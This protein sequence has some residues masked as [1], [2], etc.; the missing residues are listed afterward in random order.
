MQGAYDPAVYRALKWRRRR[1]QRRVILEPW[2]CRTGEKPGGHIGLQMR[3]WL[4]R[5]VRRPHAVSVVATKILVALVSTSTPE[6]AK[7]A[8][9]TVEAATSAHTVATVACDEAAATA[10]VAS[11]AKKKKDR[12]PGIFLLTFCLFFRFFSSESLSRAVLITCCKLIVKERERQPSERQ[13]NR[14][15]LY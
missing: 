14:S 12:K 3:R 9:T 4:H 7:V 10:G 6:T 8:H 5:L 11:Q 1:G 15:I 13:M 2:C